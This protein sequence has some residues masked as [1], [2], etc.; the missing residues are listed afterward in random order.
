MDRESPDVIEAELAATRE[1]LAAKLDAAEH[2]TVGVIREAIT[3]LEGD[4]T[5]VQ[6]VVTDTV[7]A[8]RNELT[9]SVQEVLHMFDP[10]PL[11]QQNPISAV[12][13][14]MLGGFVTGLFAFRPHYPRHVTAA[15]PGTDTSDLATHGADSHRSYA[16]GTGSH[17]AD[18]HGS[19]GNGNGQGWIGRLLHSSPVSGYLDRIVDTLQSELKKAAE[20]VTSTLTTT[21]SQQFSTA[22]QTLS[23]QVKE[24]ATNLTSNLT[25][26]VSTLIPGVGGD[27]DNNATPQATGRPAA[28]T[29]N[30]GC[31]AG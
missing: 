11:I 4:V 3:N 15:A 8:V 1:S 10:R 26:K 14:A 13:A 23:Q 16:F 2:K 9:A 17:G 27:K 24:G 21:L 19:H 28:T 22:S 31:Y 20:Q 30:T 12:G 6:S 7:G 29:G 5:S 18:G 25:D